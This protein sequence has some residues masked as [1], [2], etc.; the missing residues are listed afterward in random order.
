MAKKSKL[1]EKLG[2]QTFK[3]KQSYLAALAHEVYKNRS[4]PI[5]RKTTKKTK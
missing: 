5:R 2:K 1:V 4:K 3:D